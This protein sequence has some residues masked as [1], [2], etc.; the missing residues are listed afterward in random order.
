MAI[1]ATM[2]LVMTLTVTFLMVA[3]NA[4]YSDIVDEVTAALAAIET[5]GVA[6]D[7]TREKHIAK[8]MERS[9]TYGQD[10][11]NQRRN[12]K[13]T[14][15]FEPGDCNST[16]SHLSHHAAHI[17]INLVSY[18]MLVIISISYRIYETH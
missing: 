9:S 1:I 18:I 10:E 8:T 12:G 5:A 15:A 14:L 4:A 3:N 2:N 11:R 16:A 13:D 17:T 7:T 6:D